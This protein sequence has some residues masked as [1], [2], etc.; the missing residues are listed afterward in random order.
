MQGQEAIDV[1][2]SICRTQHRYV[3]VAGCC[4]LLA[5]L[6]ASPGSGTRPIKSRL[7]F[8]AKAIQVHQKRYCTS[9]TT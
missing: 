3:K 8:K 6:A 1:L 7:D 9:T 2:S 4:S 5:P